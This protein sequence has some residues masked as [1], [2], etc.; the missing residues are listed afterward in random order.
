MAGNEALH[1]LSDRRSL[2][3]HEA[4]ATRLRSEPELIQRAR[5]RVTA[6][7]EEP[8]RHP[9][10]PAWRDLLDSGPEKLCQAL[11]SA[12]PMMQ[13][14]R[15]ASPFAGA[16]DSRTRWQILKRP[17]LKAHAAR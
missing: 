3:L 9:Y 2:A 12:D 5:A 8:E 11:I 4:V 10:A 17:D 1:V 13:T 6:W 14:L 16:I 15:Q 7:L